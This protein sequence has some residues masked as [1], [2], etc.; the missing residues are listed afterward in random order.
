VSLTA[1]VP[2]QRQLRRP[3]VFLFGAYSSRANRLAQARRP[4]LRQ[5]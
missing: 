2:S 3:R 5:P 4:W 1:R